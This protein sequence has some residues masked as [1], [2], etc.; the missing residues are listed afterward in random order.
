MEERSQRSLRLG[1]GRRLAYADWG[2]REGAPVFFFHGI[3]GGRLTRYGPTGVLEARDVRLITL[4]RV[5]AS[6]T[7]R[8]SARSHSGSM[9]WGS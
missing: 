1:D 4:D 8:P 7:R 6:R 9:I 3:P 2:S 5:S